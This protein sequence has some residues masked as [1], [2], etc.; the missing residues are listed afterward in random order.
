MFLLEIYKVVSSANKIA[1]QFS[2]TLC[3]SLLKI[4]KIRGP[5]QDPCGV[6]TLTGSSLENSV[7]L[8]EAT[9]HFTLIL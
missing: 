3:K 7:F 5:K 1:E 2:T 8:L 9:V 4:R 6:P